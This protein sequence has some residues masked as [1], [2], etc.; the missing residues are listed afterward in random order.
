MRTSHARKSG[1]KYRYYVSS[2]LVDGRPEEAGSIS[3]VPAVEIET[4]VASAI[5]EHVGGAP[6]VDDRSIIAAHQPQVV[7]HPKEITIRIGDVGEA[8]SSR[9]GDII[10]VRWQKQPPKRRREVLLP[11]SVRSDDQRPIRSETRATL[12]AAIAR[13]RRWLDELVRS[14]NATAD[15]IAHREGCSPRKVTMTIS[16]AFLSPALVKAALEG[17][18]PR[19]IGVTRLCD[20]PAEWS[21]QHQALGLN[22]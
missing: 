4:M 1:I 16:L 2:A 21:R 15:S 12:I 10:R 18:L 9:Q 3:R 20:M 13:G 6:A 8:D 22:L 11:A 7:I 14:P 5:R 17:R 19:G